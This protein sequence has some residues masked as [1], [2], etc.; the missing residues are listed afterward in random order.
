[1]ATT[2][3]RAWADLGGEL[4][5][6]RTARGV[7]QAALA[8]RAGVSLIYVQSLEQGV[9]RSPSLPVLERLAD[10]LGVELRVGFV[11]RRKGARHGR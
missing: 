3:S 4:R 7:T 10:A 11:P 9:R 1:M 6:L 8:E 5:R 2:Q